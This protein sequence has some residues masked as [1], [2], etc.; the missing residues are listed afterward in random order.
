MPPG[1]RRPGRLR[2]GRADEDARGRRRERSAGA[3]RRARHS[4][5]SATRSGSATATARGPRTWSRRRSS[6]PG[7]NLDLARSECGRRCGR[8]CSPSPSAWPSTPTGPGGP[9]RPRW[10]RR[11]SPSVPAHGRA[12]GH[13]RPDRRRRR[14][15]ALS[16]E[17]RAV[18]VETYYR[19]RTVAEAARVLGIPPGTVKSRCHYALRALKLALAERGVTHMRCPEASTALGAYVLGALEPDERR[20]GGGPPGR[21]RDLLGGARRARGLAGA[22][23]RVRPEDLAPVP[24]T[25]SPEL[26]ARV[27]AVAGPGGPPLPHAGP[28]VAAALLVVLG[29]G[30]RR[31]RLGR[32][33]RAR[34]PSPPRRGRWRSR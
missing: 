21:L 28:L 4:C 2:P 27:S 30:H 22:A 3:L 11:R 26:F 32:R 24:V 29:L 19:G 9:G 31:H 8:G 10:G 34:G 6:A 14:A 17:H 18:I 13:P 20:R 1:S 7:G 16:P 12:R 33:G 15:R 5:C 23:G 25:P